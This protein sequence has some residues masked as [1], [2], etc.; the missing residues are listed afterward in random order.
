MSLSIRPLPKKALGECALCKTQRELSSW[1]SNLGGR[2]CE[3]CEP[4]LEAAEVALVAAKCGHPS[5]TRSFSAIPS[6]AAPQTGERLGQWDKAL[7]AD[8]TRSI[9]IAALTCLM[10]AWPCG[11]CDNW[12][13]LQGEQGTA[14]R[15]T[16]SGRPYGPI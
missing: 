14:T 10:H 7:S 6:E 3:N 1:D 13:K 16:A 8:S 9:T 11:H 4:F 12:R 5:D 15:T 2:I